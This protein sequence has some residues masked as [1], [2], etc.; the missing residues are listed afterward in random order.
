MQI[1]RNA[2]PKRW[3]KP[4]ILNVVAAENAQIGADSILIDQS[5]PAANGTTPNFS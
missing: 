4:E 1:S 3:A 2:A 5:F